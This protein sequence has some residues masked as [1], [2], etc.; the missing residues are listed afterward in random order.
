M[1]YPRSCASNYCIKNRSTG[2]EYSSRQR[3]YKGRGRTAVIL[4]EE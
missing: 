2:F 1:T 4:L 3:I